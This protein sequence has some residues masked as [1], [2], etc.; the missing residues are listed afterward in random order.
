MD[1]VNVGLEK[2]TRTRIESPDLL[3]IFVLDS[4]FF[5]IVFSASLAL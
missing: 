2:P 3:I 5:F 4:V 1:A